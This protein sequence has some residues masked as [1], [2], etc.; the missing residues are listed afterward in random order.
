MLNG[1]YSCLTISAA[2]PLQTQWTLFEATRGNPIAGDPTCVQTRA[3]TNIPRSG[4]VGLPMAWQAWINQWRATLNVRFSDGPILRW[5]EGTSA[6]LRF[7]DKTYASGPLL[8]L[9]CAPQPVYL[10][11]DTAEMNARPYGRDPMWLREHIAYYVAI[12]SSERDVKDVK[13][14]LSHYTKD[15]RL[16]CW[17]HLDGPVHQNVS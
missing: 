11:K 2:T 14:W 13:D 6:L 7:N 4:L 16:L 1:L 8:D 17:I 10:D 15:G 12:E 5:L 9:V 3:H